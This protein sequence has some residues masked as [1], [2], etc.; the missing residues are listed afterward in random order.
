M[1]LRPQMLCAHKNYG[2]RSDRFQYFK[3][4]WYD[5]QQIRYSI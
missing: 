4:G 2:T 1:Y 3:T 5:G